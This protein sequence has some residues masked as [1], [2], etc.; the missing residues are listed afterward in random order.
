MLQKNVLTAQLVR[1]FQ[2]F[3]SSIDNNYNNKCNVWEVHLDILHI[4]LHVLKFTSISY[5]PITTAETFQTSEI[6]RAPTFTLAN[7]IL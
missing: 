5:E 1:E 7:W 2:L 6:M 3:I 4:T